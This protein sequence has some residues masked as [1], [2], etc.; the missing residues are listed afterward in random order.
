[1]HISRFFVAGLLLTAPLIYY[2]QDDLT[3]GI[4]GS[5]D[6]IYRTSK[7]KSKSISPE[8]FTGA[9]GEGGK[10]AV[11]TAASSPASG[12]GTWTSSAMPSPDGSLVSLAIT[13]AC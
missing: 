9:K 7:A 2:A 3:H 8:N 13:S 5:L 11:G 4:I 10:A 6:N 1:M 12:D